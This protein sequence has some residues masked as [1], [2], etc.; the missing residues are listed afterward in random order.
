MKWEF[1]FEIETAAYVAWHRRRLERKL[2]RIERTIR[3]EYE[4]GAE[5]ADPVLMRRALEIRAQLG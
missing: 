1:D 4:Q 2:E 3:D 5:K